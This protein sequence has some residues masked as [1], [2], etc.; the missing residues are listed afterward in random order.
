MKKNDESIGAWLVLLVFVFLVSGCRDPAGHSGVMET[1][2]SATAPIAVGKTEVQ[3]PTGPKVLVVSTY[4]DRGFFTE[5]RK[6]KMERYQC[7]SCH[8]NTE[9]RRANAK[10]VVH[11]IIR[12]DHG[13]EDDEKACATCHNSDSRDYLVSDANNAIDFN[14]SYQLCGQCHFRQEKD[15]VGG[16]HG[17]RVA[18]W[19]GKRLIKNCTS[20]HNPHSPKFAKRWPATYSIPIDGLSQS[21]IH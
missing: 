19:D 12:L 5:T 15:W 1:I 21:A 3:A 7:S 16:A 6:D 20:C 4:Q 14:H 8:D 17:K 18:N 13:A 10:E 11:G 9:V 2:K